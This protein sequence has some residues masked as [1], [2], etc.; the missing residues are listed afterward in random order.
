[1][2]GWSRGGKST[3]ASGIVLIGR[4]SS[5]LRHSS[6]TEFCE[7]TTGNTVGG[8][9]LRLRMVGELRRERDRPRLSRGNMI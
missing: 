1:M 5:P 8:D 9:A 4:I 7:I 3:E 6:C 2:T